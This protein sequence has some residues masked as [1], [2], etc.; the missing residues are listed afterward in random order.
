MTYKTIGVKIIS[1]LF[2]IAFVA[3]GSAQNADYV[4]D[5]NG[6]GALRIGMPRVEIEKMI[7]QKLILKNAMD[8]A[9]SWQDSATAKYKNITVLLFFQRQYTAD[10]EY[11]M[12]LT[13]MRTSSAL[14]KTIKGIGM[15]DDKLKI[16]AAYKQDRLLMSPEYDDQGHA[17][18]N[19]KYLISIKNESGDRRMVFYLRN[20]KVESIEVSTV[21]TDEE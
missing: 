2:F 20:K 16:I 13:G 17:I 8:T 21:F 11:Y 12:Y 9:D 3:K 1:V 18:K 19:N 15:G 7:T 10:K 4:V 14:C 5:M 6:I